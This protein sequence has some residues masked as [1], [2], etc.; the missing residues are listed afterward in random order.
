MNTVHQSLRLYLALVLG[1]VCTLWA[2]R[3]LSSQGI[4]NLRL[5]D[6]DSVGLVVLGGLGI[7]L[8]PQTGFADL[9]DNHVT[10]W[11]RLGRPFLI[12][13]AFGTA[14]VLVFKLVIHP[15]PITALTPFMQPFPY[16]VLLFGSGALYVEALYRLI[17]IPLLMFL[18]GRF[19]PNKKR[20]ERLFW[21]LAL[22]TSL[23][24]PLEQLI[25]DSPG[26]I[27]Y[28]FVTG[29]AMNLLQAVYFRRY[30]FLASLLV[31]LGHYA[32][33]HVGFGLWVEYSQ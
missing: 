19:L 2:G 4:P 6:W 7:W 20:N 15:E 22:L 26:L 16:S 10:N 1:A 23:A 33:W 24:E 14:D 11:Q 25:T 21:L 17:P 18:I 29:Y 32:L 31:R 8:A 13:L 9:L 30:G 28:S 12:G 3:Y 27:V 5:F